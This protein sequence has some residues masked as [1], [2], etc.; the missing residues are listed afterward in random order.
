MHP[1]SL[2]S[3]LR[4]AALL[5]ASPAP[6]SGCPGPWQE[7]LRLR[8]HQGA[9]QQ[10]PNPRTESHSPTEMAWELHQ[11][12][13]ALGPSRGPPPPPRRSCFKKDNRDCK[14]WLVQ[15]A[16]QNEQ[17]HES[18]GELP[19]AL[20]SWS[21]SNNLYCPG[22][23]QRKSRSLPPGAET[24]PGVLSACGNEEPQADSTGMV[25]SAGGLR[26]HRRQNSRE[27]SGDH[28]LEA[29]RHE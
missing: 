22:K 18:T 11:A 21:L 15:F 9:I 25:P 27:N 6:A 14:I 20:L 12:E 17:I 29:W 23:R 4:K 7:A 3:G 1:V 8:K 28:Q 10:H 16:P 13:F 26:S 24:S 19:C 5:W 2:L